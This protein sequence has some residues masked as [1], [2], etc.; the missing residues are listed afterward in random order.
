[1]T[2]V[3]LWAF[4]AIVVA[5]ASGRWAALMAIPA[6]VVLVIAARA[7]RL[8]QAGQLLWPIVLL[9]GAVFM[10][11]GALQTM[12]YGRTENEP[13]VTDVLARSLF[14]GTGMLLHLVA[15]A[16]LAS[17]PRASDHLSGEIADRMP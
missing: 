1:M 6:A 5:A 17:E 4:S 12:G 15:F 16:L 13:A 2:L 14:F 10:F 9:P 11:V 8:S 7:E 3:A